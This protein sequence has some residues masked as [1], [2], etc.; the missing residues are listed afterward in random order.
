[1][2][3]MLQEMVDELLDSGMDQSGIENGL[4]IL[5]KM[6]RDH[7]KSVWL[8]SHKDELSSRVNQVFKVV[9][10]SGFTAFL[11]DIDLK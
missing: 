11:E 2:R 3:E 9:K 7:N 4:S 6:T 10:E 8:I 5:K 1:M